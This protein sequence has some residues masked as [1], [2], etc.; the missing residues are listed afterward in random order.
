MYDILK[1][2]SFLNF[3]TLLNGNFSVALYLIVCSVF[4]LSYISIP[5]VFFK[6][7]SEFTAQ[8][9]AITL[10][11]L[12][13]GVDVTGNYVSMSSGFSCLIVEGCTPISGILIYSAFV[14]TH[15]STVKEKF[16][17]FL[18]GI[19]SLTLANLLRLVV[20][21]L[22]SSVNSN[23][24]QVVHLYFG[25]LMMTTSVIALCIYWGGQKK[26]ALSS[27]PLF[28]YVLRIFLTFSLLFFP[29]LYIYDFYVCFINNV[30]SLIFRIFNYTVGMALR[31]NE[32]LASP[33]R[34]IF[35][36]SLIFSSQRL[37]K[38]DQLKYF[39][40]G[41]FALAFIHILM[42]SCIIGNFLKPHILWAASYKLAATAYAILPIFMWMAFVYKKKLFWGAC[43]K[44]YKS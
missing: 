10:T 28:F 37:A 13:N 1:S 8:I 34:I 7:F 15:P 40:I 39:L 18:I 2:K 19:P 12:G 27:K 21:F 29:W 9:L 36:A 5:P 31:E 6:P 32:I 20:T 26:M 24:F 16:Y 43:S 4:L 41:F 30:T 42:N 14:L 35:F 33:F 23:F 22:I 11:M 38:R 44:D 3:G 25:Q 17:G